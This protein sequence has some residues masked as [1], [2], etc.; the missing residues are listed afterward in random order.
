MQ[1]LGIS[2]NCYSPEDELEIKNL[3]PPVYAVILGT[4]G[5]YYRFLAT[6]LTTQ[7]TFSVRLM[8]ESELHWY[9]TRYYT[10]KARDFKGQL[11]PH[12]D[13]HVFADGQPVLTWILKLFYDQN[14]PIE[15]LLGSMNLIM[16]FGSVVC[17]FFVYLLLQKANVGAWTSVAFALINRISES[18]DGSPWRT[19]PL[20]IRSSFRPFGI[21]LFKH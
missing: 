21:F 6:S 18:A 4:V 15:T 8:M 12:G 10:V 9:F 13:L 2:R 3:L 7:P 19:L 20:L 17:A 5:V 14:T 11:Y 16:I 1:E